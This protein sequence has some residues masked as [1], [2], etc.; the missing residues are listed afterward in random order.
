MVAT[1]GSRSRV[2]WGSDF[3][4]VYTDMVW[5]T[6][7]LAATFDGLGFT[8]VNEGSFASIRTLPDGVLAVTT[9]TGDDDNAFFVG[10]PMKPANGEGWCEARF[11]TNSA[12]LG[13]I[14]MGYTSVLAIDTPIMP[15]EFATATMTYNASAT[16][17]GLNIDTDGTIVDARAVFA[18]A[19]VVL[20]NADA[21]GTRAYDTLAA[22]EWMI[23]RIEV[24]PNGSA[25]VKFG[26]AGEQLRVV[27][28][29]TSGLPTGTLL[30]PC[31]GFEN[32]SAAARVFSVDYFFGGNDRDWTN[33]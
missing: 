19:G 16:Q 28:E 12:T 3:V 14:Y 5:G 31:L 29:I 18:N 11:R 7:Q 26:H 24:R 15:A 23:A 21:N 4:G 20:S 1:Q 27:K 30:F 25:L 33:S 9:D 22:N 8:S 13:A 17:A 2:Q 6:G 10:P 32:R